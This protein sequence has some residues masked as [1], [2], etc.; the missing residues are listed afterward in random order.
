[1]FLRVVEEPGLHLI[2]RNVFCYGT[3]VSSGV[4]GFIVIQSLDVIEEKKNLKE[5]IL[6][7]HNLL[8]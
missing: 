1:M 6:L 8:L 3:Q 7:G 5:Y 4:S 2:S